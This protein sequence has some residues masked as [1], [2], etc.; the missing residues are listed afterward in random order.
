MLED[1]SSIVAV[2]LAAGISRRMGSPKALLDL[3]GKPLIARLLDSVRSVSQIQQIVVVTGHQ[4]E[5]IQQAARGDRTSFT[6]NP[7]YENGEMLSSIQSGI[8]A[9]PKP[10]D[11]FFIMLLDQ[12]LVRPAT[13]NMQIHA[14]RET[15]PAI[16]I[17]T[18]EGKRGHPLLFDSHCLKPISE[19]P[20]NGS[21]RDFVT[22]QSPEKICLV[23]ADD[24]PGVT[25]D[26][27]TRADYEQ[28]LN[29]WK[30]LSRAESP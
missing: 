23:R 7:N 28:V 4:P 13:F 8:G 16:V 1:S 22:T 29:L 20:A 5:K 9:I 17:P 27:D 11:A 26:V 15:K 21:L 19:I 30:K 14:W 24:D 6:H 12:P 18:C 3:G 25:T 2:V 10:C